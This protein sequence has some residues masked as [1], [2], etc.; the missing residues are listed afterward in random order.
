MTGFVVSGGALMTFVG[1]FLAGLAGFFGWQAR[2]AWMRSR[3]VRERVTGLGS[4]RSGAGARKDALVCWM[5]RLSTELEHGQVRRRCPQRWARSSWFMGQAG[6][7]GLAGRISEPAFCEARFRLCAGLGAC[8]AAVGWSFSFELGW[9]LGVCGACLGWRL[10]AKSVK[11]R[12]EERKSSL[13]AHLPEMLDVL[14]LGMGSGLSFDAAV[15]LCCA[16][17]STEAAADLERARSSWEAGLE[18]REE[19]LRRFASS[20]DSPVLTRVTDSWIRSLRFGTSMVEG[21]AAEA[22]QAR[23]AYKAQREE[24]IAKAP[25]KMMVP[26]GTLIL[27]AM[28]VLV[29]GPVLLELMTGGF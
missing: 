18:P 11:R 12:R 7:A 28:L 20:Y 15:K 6:S 16:H 21:L 1:L 8:G 2:A 25:V 23:A 14:A 26:T 4:V 9:L 24:R 29:L 10:P 22:A 19:A 5:E 3:H 17:A 27:P 13:E